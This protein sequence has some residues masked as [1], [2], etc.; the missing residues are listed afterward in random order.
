MKKLF[1]SCPMKGRT[2]ENIKKSMDKMHKLAEIMFE[3]EL[4][5]IPQFSNLKLI[6]SVLKII[7]DAGN[8]NIDFEYI[9]D[10]LHVSHSQSAKVKYGENHL[11]LAVQMGLVLRNPYRVTNLGK[12]YLLMKETEQNEMN[13]K[14]FMKIPIIQKIIVEASTE[15]INAQIAITSWTPSTRQSSCRFGQVHLQRLHPGFG[16]P[17]FFSEDSYTRSRYLRFVGL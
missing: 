11:K 12:L 2:E 14:L 10:K 16:I 7:L 6:S 4:E 5:V 15:K 17:E 3:Q 1:I 13:R 8:D 9:G